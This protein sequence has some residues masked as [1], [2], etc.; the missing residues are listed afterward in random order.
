MP[1]LAFSP[2]RNGAAKP[3]GLG[4]LVEPVEVQIAI[5]QCFSLNPQQ[6]SVTF[7]NLQPRLSNF[8]RSGKLRPNCAELDAT[9]IVVELGHNGAPLADAGGSAIG[10][11]AADAPTGGA[12]ADV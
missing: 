3:N 12:E 6:L 8:V 4:L 7:S 5:T 9:T 10:L 1:P 11:S 2:R